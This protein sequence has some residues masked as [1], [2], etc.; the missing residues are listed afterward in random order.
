MTPYQQQFFD[1][2]IWM[3]QFDKA[4]SWY[5]SKAY[6]EMDTELSAMPVTL[7]EYMHT[8]QAAQAAAKA[9]AK[10]KG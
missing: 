3:A 9:I 5:A 1:H 7:T 2:L 8:K 6:A 4:Y 10:A